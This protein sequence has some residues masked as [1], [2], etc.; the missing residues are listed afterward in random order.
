MLAHTTQMR[1]RY[2]ETDQMGYVYYGVYPQYYEVGRAEWLRRFGITYKELEQ[3][4][5]IMPVAEVHIKYLRPARYDDLLTQITKVSSIPDRRVTFE[6]EIFNAE[7]QLLNKGTVT[8]AF[9]DATSMQACAAPKLL[10]DTILPYFAANE[11][12]NPTMDKWPSCY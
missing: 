11:G 6:T 10:L 7:G 12:E 3:T 4:G 5:V 8:L 2:A 9:V 1:V